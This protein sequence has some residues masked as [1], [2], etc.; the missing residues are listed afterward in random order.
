MVA[1]GQFAQ[2]ALAREVKFAVVAMGQGQGVI[3]AAD[4]K[5]ACSAMELEK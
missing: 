4:W 5:N 1:E 2:G 3:S